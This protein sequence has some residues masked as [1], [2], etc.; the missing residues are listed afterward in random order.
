VKT[1]RQSIA[2]GGAGNGTGWF[3]WG[4]DTEFATLSAASELLVQ[5]V[6]APTADAADQPASAT[7]MMRFYGGSVVFV[8]NLAAQAA[9]NL[10]LQVRRAGSVLGGAGLFGWLASGAGTPAFTAWVPV[11]LPALTANANLIQDGGAGPFFAQLRA[12]DVLTLA[13]SGTVPTVPAGMIQPS[14][15]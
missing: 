3:D 4:A 14:A 8:S 5:T 9:L 15:N 10:V 13:F 1:L 7:S 12:G 6:L 2:T 11:A